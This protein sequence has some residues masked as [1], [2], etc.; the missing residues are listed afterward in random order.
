MA[1]NSLKKVLI[2]SYF[3]PPCNLT[4]SER[5]YSWAKWLHKY[6]YYPVIISRKWEKKLKS[7]KDVS[8]PS[9]KG[10]LH[11]KF[12]TH[13]VYYLPYKGNLRDKI[14]RKYGEDKYG[15]IRQTLTFF[16]LIF[17]FF[18]NKVIPYENI[19]TFSKKLLQKEKFEHLIISGNPFNLFK[20]GFLL[21]KKFKIPWTADYRDAW[22]T[23]E[24]NDNS[25]SIFKKI[26]HKLDEK[27]ERK[28]VST[29]SSITASSKPI[30][31]SIEKITGVKSYPIFNG[32]VFEDF[33]IVKKSSK[34][35]DFTI[36]YIGTLYDGQKIEVFCDAYKKFIDVTPNVKTK[37][38]FPG[39]SFFGNQES[40]VDAIM[41]NYESYYECSDRIPREEILTLEK[42][43]HLLLHVA[44]QGYKGIIASKIYEYI[45]SGT[46]IIVAPSDEG[47]IEEIIK[48]SGCGE[49]LSKKHELVKF[50]KSEYQNFKKGETS[51]NDIKKSSVQQFSR[52]KQ[53]ES[54]VNSVLT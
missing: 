50:L 19:Y 10:V 32:I 23:S 16:E 52:Q 24:I 36:T 41:K 38:L 8:I 3:F 6:G 9:S 7:L 15:K 13:E 27:F 25:S 51:K 48:L 34:F 20:F 30:G 29:A 21:H 18:S 43:A 40:R 39:L 44:W 12:D 1:Q 54:L 47:A 11:E 53:V 46:K 2:I 17:Q 22:S 28:W 45:A 14:Y 26:V 42:R 5:T 31:K 49:V 37:L 33:D 4:A 35:D